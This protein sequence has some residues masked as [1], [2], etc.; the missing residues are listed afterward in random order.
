MLVIVHIQII[1]CIQPTEVSKNFLRLHLGDDK[2]SVL[3]ARVLTPLCFWVT[4]RRT[5]KR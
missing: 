5:A 3:I 1:V 2:S 4:G